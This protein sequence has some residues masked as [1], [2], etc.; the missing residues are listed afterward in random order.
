MS[1]TALIRQLLSLSPVTSICPRL[2]QNL[3]PKQVRIFGWVQSRL[4]GNI[5]KTE[6]NPSHQRKNLLLKHEGKPDRCNSAHFPGKSAARGG[7]ED[8][9]FSL[10]ERPGARSSG[11]SA[12]GIPWMRGLFERM[13]WMLPALKLSYW[14]RNSPW[15]LKGTVQPFVKLQA[16]WAAAVH[17]ASEM[18]G[19]SP[20]GKDPVWGNWIWELSPL[21]ARICCREHSVTLRSCGGHRQA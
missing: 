2:G 15:D 21:G 12:W 16:L 1:C 6:L 20:E 11:L 5:Y 17:T 10:S 13:P 18:E 7:W 9:C 14:M 4:S 8:P 19:C 3:L